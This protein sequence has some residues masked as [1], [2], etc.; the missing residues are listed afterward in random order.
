MLSKLG[1]Y[2]QTVSIAAVFGISLN[3]IIWY[4]KGSFFVIWLLLAFSYLI[5]KPVLVRSL[6]NTLFKANYSVN[7]YDGKIAMLNKEMQFRNLDKFSKKSFEY[8]SIIM[9]IALFSHF[10]LNNTSG[11]CFLLSFITIC[12]SLTFLGIKFFYISLFNDII[13]NFSY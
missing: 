12:Q 13:S 10:Y 2:Y 1:F 3:T 4:F 5:I 6:K 8:S 7:N 9:L 11:F